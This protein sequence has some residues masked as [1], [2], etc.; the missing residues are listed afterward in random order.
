MRIGTTERVL[1]LAARAL[2]RPCPDVDA[3]TPGDWT[4]LRR[5]VEVAGMLRP[6]RKD[7][8]GAWLMMFDAMSEGHAFPV[9]EAQG[10]APPSPLPAPLPIEPRTCKCDEP[11]PNGLRAAVAAPGWCQT[12]G[13]WVE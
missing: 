8:Y 10:H 2:V 12:C 7:D 5:E 9:S 11:R 4:K 3:M 13:G 1:I 6:N